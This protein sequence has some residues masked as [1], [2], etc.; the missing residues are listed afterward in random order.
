M[1]TRAPEPLTPYFHPTTACFIDDNESFLTGLELML[2]EHMNSA[3]F[4]DPVEALKYV[5]QPPPLP[6][7][8]DRC[9]TQQANQ[10]NPL[11]SLDIGLIEQEINLPERFNRISVVVVDYSMPT[12]SGLEFCKRITDPHIGKVLLTGVADEK[13]AVEAFNAG[14]I[15][16]FISKSHA[17]ASER[18]SEFS[19][20]MQQA[21][22]RS[23]AQ[24]LQSTLGLSAPT[25][26]NSVRV[27]E[28]VRR[29]MR[30]HKFCE[31][32]LANSPPGLVL[33]RPNGQMQ[34]F[35]ILT[36]QQVA[37]Q[38]EFAKTY[39]APWLVQRRL[40]KA[41]HVGFFLESPENY[42]ED[43]SYPWAQLLHRAVRIA[44]DDQT[45]HAAMVKHPPLHIDY[46]PEEVSLDA[47]KATRNPP[48]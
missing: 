11:Y 6:S 30:K 36:A 2:P 44:D 8:A 38:A 26:L 1:F 29:I 39:D 9:F 42:V 18:I 20:S 12:L 24:Q 28:F 16:R 13:T 37:A 33:L 46:R 21:Y 27:A 19:A 3:S 40:N 7:L 23:Q 10:H 34:Q 25:F 5:N 31:Y 48:A 32:Y 17:L 14:I 35:I 15:D 47:F 43:E 22:F 45:W 41:S 4:F